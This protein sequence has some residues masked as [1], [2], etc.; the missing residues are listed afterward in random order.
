MP[1]P[2]MDILLAFAPVFHQR[3]WEKIPMMMAGAILAPG[4]RTVS[5]LLR[6]MG[7]SAISNFARYHHVLS[8]AV[9]SPLRGSQILLGLLVKHLA[10]GEL[11]LV[12]GIDETI[13]RRWGRKIAAR[14][15][16]RD[17]VRSSQSHFVKAS[18]LRWISLMWLAAIPWAQRIWALPVLTALAPSKR[19]YERSARGPKKLTD[20]ARQVIFQLRRWLPDQ[21]IVVVG[22]NTY[23]VL[24]LLHACQSL[25]N[26][27]TIIA[28]LRMDAALYEPA[29]PPSGKKGR[30]RKK[31]KRLPT[32]QQCLEDS[33]TVWQVFK[34]TWYN[35]QQR[36][37]ELASGTAVWYHSGK[38][39][40][41]IRWVLIRDPLGEY[42]PIALLSTHQSYTPVQIVQWFVQRWQLEVTFQEVRAH[43]GVETQRQWSDKAIARTTPVLLA[44]FSWVTLAAHLLQAQQPLPI[45]PAAWYSKSLPTFSDAIAFV[46]YH[47]WSHQ[48][49]FCLSP[50]DQDIVKMPRSLLTR[51]IDTLCY[52]A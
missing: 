41:P 15:I 26:P 20:W 36:H 16:Y 48:H 14:G 2:I 25:R 34:L 9:W 50:T 21:E 13:E 24:D 11:P 49:I 7:L 23:A 1:D 5:S 4:K 33:S 32:L 40:V 8:R 39:P 38:P 35:G 10:R 37:M 47:L 22:D 19:Y 12:F 3:T 44:L 18:G 51:L 46:R 28:R 31:G 27:V 30:P 29:P 6:V 43:L 17:A 52:A 42:D 45:R